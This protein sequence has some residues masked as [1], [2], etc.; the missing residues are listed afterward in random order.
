MLRT[1]LC[2]LQ[3][4]SKYWR[5]WQDHV[6]EEEE[7][8]LYPQIIAGQTYYRYCSTCTFRYT[9][10]LITM[11]ECAIELQCI[12][13]SIFLPSPKCISENKNKCQYTC[14]FCLNGI[15]WTFSPS[16]CVPLDSASLTKSFF[17]KWKDRLV[18][19]RHLQVLH[20]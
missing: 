7:K 11:T 2:Y 20:P 18:E 17:Y 16:F 4:K 19:R 13:D 10:F 6:E 5:F 3:L 9:R 12:D 8:L 15:I 14:C 1:F